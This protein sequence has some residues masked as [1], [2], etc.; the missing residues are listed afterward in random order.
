MAL[1][2]LVVYGG[3]FV[4]SL[5]AATILPAQSELALGAAL[6][7][8][9]YTPWSLVLVATAGNTA[10]ALVN[11]YLAQGLFGLADRTRLSPRLRRSQQ[12]F[13]KF[14]VWSLLFS[15]LPIIGDIVTIAA[16]IAGTRLRVFLPL[17]AAGKGAR[18]I[19]VAM[20]A[21][22]ATHFCA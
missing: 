13:S 6:A 16:G 12:I 5:V 20:L 1:E 11:Y 22:A 8:T 17:V 3:L 19:V 14:G 10:G 9:T 2:L 18:Y 4:V 7:G 21:C 15:W